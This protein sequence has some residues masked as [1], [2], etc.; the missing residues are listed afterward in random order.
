MGANLDFDARYTNERLFAYEMAETLSSAIYPPM[1][2]LVRPIA[3]Y[4]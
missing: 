4:G 1:A 3:R 2:R